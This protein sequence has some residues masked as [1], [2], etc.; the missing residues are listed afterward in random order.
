[1]AMALLVISFGVLADLLFGWLFIPRDNL[2]RCPHPAYH[3]GLLPNRQDTTAWGEHRV[4]MITNSLGF[5]DQATR[6]VSPK[7]KD[8]RLLILGDSFTEG[9]GVR[10]QETFA[11]LLAKTLAPRGVE[12]LNGAVVSYSPKLYY[13]KA[14]HLIEEEGLE[15]DQLAVF[16]D[17]SDIQ[18]EISYEEFEPA[19]FSAMSRVS[20]GL[21]QF[22][23]RR[24]FL[25]HSISKLT[26]ADVSA[27]APTDQDHEL[28]PCLHGM[29]V[30]TMADPLF[31]E[32][33]SMWTI[34]Q[35][36]FGK[37]GKR[38]L[39]L[40]IEN[41]NKL[42]A[43]CKASGIQ[44][45]VVVYPWPQQI[46]H[47]LLENLQVTAWRSFAERQGARFVDLFPKFIDQRPYAAVCSKYFL[48]GDVHWNEAGHRLVADT[49]A[50]L[51][52]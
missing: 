8:R 15:F 14:R 20:F 49:L 13:L 46:Q 50:P 35:A 17:I 30:A 4:E 19:E 40:A 44:L 34:K 22:G 12:V 7:P 47:R 23:R 51:F 52:R 27:H 25:F 1:M 33:A 38:G 21:K 16:I 45:T 43:L 11:G 6:Q 39:D 10:Y 31:Q 36:V 2:F 3:H 24:S 32:T 41:M 42:A 28:F 48:K 26:R 5:R 29:D 37:Y 18:N 9:V